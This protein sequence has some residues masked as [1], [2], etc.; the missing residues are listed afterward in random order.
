MELLDNLLLGFSTALTWKNLSYAFIGVALGNLIGVLPGIGAI[1]AISMLLPVTYGLDP[2]G[3]LMMLAGIYYGSTYGGAT[4]SILLNLPGTAQH[5]VVCLDGNPMARQ[6]R[7][8]PALLSAMLGSFV[9]ATIGVVILALFSPILVE[10]AFQFGP[11]E[12][13]S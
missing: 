1:A 5:A 13:F 7:G 9:G 4:T 3:A 12:Y 11:A 2:A 8:G 10:L 6:G